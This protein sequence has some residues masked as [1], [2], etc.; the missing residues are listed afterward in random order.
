MLS[1]RILEQLNVREHVLIG[2]VPG[3]VAAMPNAFLFHEM[4]EALGHSTVV[5]VPTP[6]YAGYEGALSEKG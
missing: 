1:R 3:R 6:A 4:E 5:A 2:G